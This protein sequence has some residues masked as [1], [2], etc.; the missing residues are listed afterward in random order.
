MGGMPPLPS[1][2]HY[3]KGTPSRLNEVLMSFL[4][5]N[6]I[7]N[8]ASFPFMKGMWESL[9]RKANARYALIRVI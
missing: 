3:V 8:E 6:D 4:C 1:R 9:D 7:R 5:K 2:L